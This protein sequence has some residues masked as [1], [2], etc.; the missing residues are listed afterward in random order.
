M[1]SVNQKGKVMAKILIIDSDVEFLNKMSAEL[2][3]ANYEVTIAE[4]AAEGLAMAANAALIILAVELPDQNGFVVCSQLKRDAVTSE[5][6]VFITSSADGT[7]AFEQHLNLANHADGYFLKPVD[8][9]AMLQ[10]MEAILEDVRLMQAER[11][12]SNDEMIDVSSNV[13]EENSADD[14]EVIRALSAEDMSLFGE[15]DAQDLMG[16]ADEALFDAPRAASAS[17]SIGI[18]AASAPKDKPSAPVSAGA[19]ARQ[20]PAVPRAAGSMQAPAA[21]R[22]PAAPRGLPTQQPGMAGAAGANKPALPPKPGVSNTLTGMTSVASAP[23]GT[24]SAG[25][26]RAPISSALQGSR[27]PL[28]KDGGALPGKSFSSVSQVAIPAADMSRMS[29][30]ITVLK[31][32]VTALKSEITARDNRITMLQSQCDA[33]N[34]RCQ[35]AESISEALKNEAEHALSMQDETQRSSEAQ[36]ASL[37]ASLSQAQNEI[38]RLNGVMGQLSAKAQEL[39]TIV[40]ASMA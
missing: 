10:E 32:E 40:A 22:I 11:A 2:K 25:M 38:V 17:Q 6:P 16:P 30:E 8:T 27:V 21:G 5:T 37:N 23:A 12:A 20:I 18:P 34:A 1:C 19:A 29:D 35:N 39:M 28:N 9:N 4:N 15:I 31:N 7:E 14:S 3:A 13:A 33:L 24:S 36:I 26:V